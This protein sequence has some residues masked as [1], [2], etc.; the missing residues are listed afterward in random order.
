MEIICNILN[1]RKSTARN[2]TE[3]IT[4]RNTLLPTT[5]LLLLNLKMLLPSQLLPHK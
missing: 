2:I 5:A 4:E 3:D 1:N